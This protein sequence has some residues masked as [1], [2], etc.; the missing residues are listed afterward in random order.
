MASQANLSISDGQG[1]PVAHTFVAA[2]VDGKGVAL[3]LEKTTSS[4]VNGFF[5]LTQSTRLSSKITEP[6]RHSMKLVIPTIVVETVNG[7]NY[8]K[9]AR[10]SM[11]SID[12]IVAPDSTAQERKDLCVFAANNLANYSGS[13]NFG[14][15]VVNQEAVV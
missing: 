6:N 3:W 5:R 13:N 10:Q 11:I 1:T 9:V 4:L 7:V 14:Y 12:C 2:G 15:S 8:N